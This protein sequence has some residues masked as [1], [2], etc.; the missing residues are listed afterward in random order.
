MCGLVGTAG[1]LTAVTDK[2]FKTLLILDSIRGIDSTGI[3]A[4]DRDGECRVVKQVGNPYDLFGY[5]VFDLAL[6]RLNRVLIGHN[7]FATQ[8]TVTRRNAHPFDFDTLVGVHN[9]TLWN[10]HKLKDSHLFTVDS[11]NIFHHIE[12]EGLKSALEVMDG[13]WSL[14]WWD[15]LEETLNF[16]RNKERPM[17]LAHSE[18]GENMM[19]ASEP[20]MLDVAI[21]RENIK[22]FAP[23]PTI[24]DKHYSFHIDKTGKIHKPHIKDAPGKYTPPVHQGYRGHAS[25]FRSGKEQPTG[26]NVVALPEIQQPV[27]SQAT[28]STKKSRVIPSPSKQ[29]ALSSPNFYEG[30]KNVLLECLALKSDSHGARYIVCF[31]PQARANQ[32][33]LYLRRED[34]AESFLERDILCTVGKKFADG[35]EGLYYK[36]EH[37]TVKLA[38]VALAP[39]VIKEEGK[40]LLDA[41]GRRLVREVWE[42]KYNQCAWCTGWVNPEE[43]NKFTKTNDDIVCHECAADPEITQYVEL[44]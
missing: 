16:L 30:R 26:T 11:E 35:M 27:V 8:G 31:D 42:Q 32:I 21:E 44:Q 7:R 37:G 19:W 6:Q 3:A 5:K 13:A 25:N 34:K 14:V 39:V 41:R 20:W 24:I 12:T 2:Q 15:K 18:N 1:K 17:W 28:V 36:V 29:L 23:V 9:G 10:K 40:Y 43:D 38:N 4:V 22:Y 33:R